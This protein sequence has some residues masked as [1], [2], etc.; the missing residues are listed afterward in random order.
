MKLWGF[1]ATTIAVILTV[2]VILLARMIQKK[3]VSDH[4][5]LRYQRQ[6][7]TLLLSLIGLLVAIALL[8]IP[9]QIITQILSILGIFLSAVIALSSTTLVGNAM[10]GIML[11]IMRSF[12]PGDFI[13]F[14]EY[15]GRIA[16]ITLLHTEIQLINRDIVSVPNSQLVRQA[17]HVTRRSGTFVNASVSLGYSVPHETII[18]ALEKAAESCNLKE[19]F[20]LIDDLLDHAVVYRIYGL[21][22]ESQELLSKTSELRKA[23][24]NSL[25]NHTIEIVS[26]S[27][28]NR[29]EYD[30]KHPFI[31]TPLSQKSIKKSPVEFEEIVFDRVEQAESIEKLYAQKKQLQSQL[32]TDHKT[33]K[34]TKSEQI[35]TKLKAHLCTL[36]NYLEQIDREINRREKEKTET[37]DE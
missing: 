13:H 21:L 10:A 9:T 20:V 22:E 30:I 17:I 7:Y 14:N 5:I 31:P 1:S 4:R 26:P 35:K 19:S 11:Q 3:T 8:P 25:H 2:I 29:R 15:T 23:M 36:E 16:E 24:L 28:V 33:L 37:R 34:E 32:A 18:T 12:R 6:F 27:F